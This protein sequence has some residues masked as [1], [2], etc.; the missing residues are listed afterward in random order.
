MQKNVSYGKIMKKILLI[1]VFSLLFSAIAMADNFSDL[2]AKGDSYWSNR[3]NQPSLLQAIEFYKKAHAIKP[4]NETLLGRLTRAYYWKGINMLE[5]ETDSRMAA[6]QEGMKYGEKLLALNPRHVPGNFWY[7]SNMAR[8]GADRGIV[9]S[10]SYL[11]DIKE[12]I[13]LVLEE[14][15]FYFHGGAHRFIAKLSES[16]PGLLRKSLAGFDLDDSEQLLKEAIK[17]EYNFGMSHLFLADIYMTRKKP[18]LAKKEY[19]IVLQIS[20]DAL[21]EYSA[22]IRRDKK[23]AMTALKKHFIEL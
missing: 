2:M 13:N 21:P 23:A 3:D 1:T 4:K 8:L 12:K 6:F 22:E 18:E 15:R 11:S 7:A 9:K 5:E 20:E 19:Q 14:D 16:V 10:L 17:M